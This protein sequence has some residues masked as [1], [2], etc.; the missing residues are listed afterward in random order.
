VIT[1]LVPPPYGIF[2]LFSQHIKIKKQFIGILVVNDIIIRKIKDLVKCILSFPTNVRYR[3]PLNCIIRRY[4]SLKKVK[5]MGSNKVYSHTRISNSEFGLGTFCGEYCDFTF[6]KVGKWSSIGSYV[7]MCSGAHPIRDFVSMHPSFYSISGGVYK[8]YVYEQLFHEYKYITS[9]EDEKRFRVIIGNDVWI[10]NGVW[11][12][13]G[14]TIGDGAVIGAGAVVTKD[15][16]PYSIA[17]G[18][19][20]KVMRYR[21][22][23]GDIEFLLKL[24]WW[25]KEES[26]VKRAALYFFNI[27]Y[28]R[29]FCNKDEK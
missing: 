24:K 18:V 7:R 14:I 12:L 4:V 10:G 28:L 13:E 5:F 21:F 8:R 26:W 27:E 16:P 9:E 19:P 15:I 11:I 20:A 23:E 29:E 17:V 3:I 25:D 22:A 1:F 6:C 2:L